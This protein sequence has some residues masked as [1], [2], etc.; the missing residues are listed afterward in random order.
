[1][2]LAGSAVGQSQSCFKHWEMG[3]ETV[4]YLQNGIRSRNRK[5]RTYDIQKSRMHTQSKQER[6]ISPLTKNTPSDVIHIKPQNLDTTCDETSK[7]LPAGENGQKDRE[8][9]RGMWGALSKERQLRSQHVS[10]F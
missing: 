7:L 4:L 9:H 10:N 6:V 3:K 1:M 5:A 2:Q 8:G